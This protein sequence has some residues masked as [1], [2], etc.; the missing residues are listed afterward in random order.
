MPSI[1][2]KEQ[3]LGSGGVFTLLL[4]LLPRD[5][6]TDKVA[7]DDEGCGHGCAVP[8]GAHESIDGG[9]PRPRAP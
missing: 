1:N 2:E 3:I 5:H 7:A 6:H 9:C 4:R 8:A